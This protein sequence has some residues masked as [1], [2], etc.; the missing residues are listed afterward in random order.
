MGSKPDNNSR[1]DAEV[2]VPL[3]YWSNFLG[4]PNLP[5]MTIKANKKLNLVVT[6]LFLK[7]RKLSISFV[8]ISHSYFKVHKSIKHIIL[9]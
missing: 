3:K 8:F 9:S 6:E 7:G 4:S 5:L 2:F 1:L